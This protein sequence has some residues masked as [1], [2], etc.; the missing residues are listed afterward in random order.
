MVKSFNSLFESVT[1]KALEL[2]SKIGLEIELQQE[3][4]KTLQNSKLASLGEIAAGIAHEINNS[5]TISLEKLEILKRY[6]SSDKY[7][8]GNFEELIAKTISSSRR[9]TDIV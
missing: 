2:E 4:L 3:K 9:V 7:G 5:L 6:V 1:L 8:Q